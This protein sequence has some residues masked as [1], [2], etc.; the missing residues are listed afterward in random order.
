[1]VPAK[2]YTCCGMVRRCV[3]ADMSYMPD[4]RYRNRC[5]LIRVRVGGAGGAGGRSVLRD[6]S[7]DRDSRNA[8]V[9]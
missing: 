1:V 8:E 9:N 7:G 3:S 6:G 4:L 2:R 5:S